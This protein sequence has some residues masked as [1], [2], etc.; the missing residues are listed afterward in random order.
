MGDI[1]EPHP[2]AK[3]QSDWYY[4]FLTDRDDI[5]KVKGWDEVIHIKNNLTPRLK[6]K[7]PKLLPHQYLPPHD[8]SMWVD[9]AYEVTGNPDSIFYPEYDIAVAIHPSNR[10]TIWE[11]AETIL[12]YGLDTYENMTPQLERYKAEGFSGSYNN[13]IYQAGV[14]LRHNNERV[15]K[16][17]EDWCHE[18]MNGS[19]RDQLSLPYVL[20]KH[21][22]RLAKVVQVQVATI[23]K[24]WPHIKT[25][26][27]ITF[28]Q[29]W[30]FGGLIGDRI[31]KEIARI[32]NEDEWICLM[33]QDVCVLVDGFGDLINHT[34][35]RYPD[36]WLFGAY[37]NRIGLG[38]QRLEEKPSENYDMLYHHEIAQQRL[39]RY[40]STCIDIDKPVAGF[41]M[42][43]PKRVWN[44]IKFQSKIIDKDREYNGKKGV[45]FDYQFGLEVLAAGGKIRLMEGNYLYHHYRVGKGIRD[46][47]HLLRP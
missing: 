7:L 18:V 16:F 4:I 34:I 15:N 5:K 6:A 24:W 12:T 25:T 21:Q 37:C 44:Q 11:E 10:S 32:E 8:Y 22:L 23:M 1:D 35:N 46:V 26:N 36:T 13:Q 40:Y 19:I 47:A 29:P 20:D 43:F 17:N 9:A 2:I 14:I 30:G 38:Y 3:S 42:L 27:S 33:D 39:K 45:Y 28:I 41:F 31:N